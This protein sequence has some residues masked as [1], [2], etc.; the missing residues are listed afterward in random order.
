MSFIPSFGAGVACLVVY[1]SQRAN[2]S[3][4]AMSRSGF[5]AVV[6]YDNSVI[7]HIDSRKVCST[8]IPTRDPPAWYCDAFPI[9]TCILL[10]SD[11]DPMAQLLQS[12]PVCAYVYAALTKHVLL[13]SNEEASGTGHMQFLLVGT[14]WMMRCLPRVG[15]CIASPVLKASLRYAIRVHGQWGDL[16]R[17]SILCRSNWKRLKQD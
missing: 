5:F 2:E 11:T 6:I 7:L 13:C 4:Q 10:R 3:T 15:T 17:T 12:S 14:N 1:F 9:L 8:I 16:P